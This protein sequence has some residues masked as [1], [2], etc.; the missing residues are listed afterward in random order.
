MSLKKQKIPAAMKIKI[1]DSKI[2]QISSVQLVEKTIVVLRSS[3]LPGQVPSKSRLLVDI[4][5]TAIV[6]LV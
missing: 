2:R 4:F 5:N 1:R 3:L 6:S